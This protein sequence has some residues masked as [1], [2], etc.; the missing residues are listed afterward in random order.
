MVF[1]DLTEFELRLLKWISASDFVEVPWSTK[2]AA[3]AFKVDE[4]EVYE[5]LASLTLKVRDNIHIYYDEG[6]I[7]ITADDSP[8]A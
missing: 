2:R 7:R 1:E 4:R 8:T 3:D 6:A 5:A